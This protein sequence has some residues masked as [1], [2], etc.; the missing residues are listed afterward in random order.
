MAKR[1]YY[2]VLG[3][4][5]S[6]DAGEI[7]KAYRKLAM[8]YH[9]D[10]NPGSKAAE[11]KFKEAA[12]AYE[13]LS[14]S[15]KR[16]AYD[17]F[18]HEG[19][20][21]AGFEGFSGVEDIFSHFSDLFGDLFGG[22]GGGRSRSRGADLRAEVRLTF[23]EAVGGVTKDVAITRHVACETCSGSGAKPGTQPERCAT[24]G[25]RG[26]VLHQQGFFMIGTTCPHCRGEGVVIREKCKDCRGSGVTEKA[27]SLSVNIPAGVDE[28][29]RLRLAGKGEPGPRGGMPGNLYVDIHVTEDPRFK[30]DGAD[31]QSTV[32]VSFTTAALGGVAEIG[33]LDEGVTGTAQIDIPAGTQPGTVHV[34][35]GA[36]IARLDGYGRGDHYVEITVDVPRQLNERQRELLREL[37]A[38]GGEAV[39][40]AGAREER[41]TFFGRKK[42]K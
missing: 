33:T 36:G 3:V 23:A 31:V 26:Q 29:Q 21:R 34:R 41:R 38:A 42:K 8:E 12:E 27:E 13:V 5:R 2:E 9:P 6:A 25:G 11:E 18:G 15:E 1:D 7:K 40:E 4:G 10:R 22:S 16:S 24:C 28:G 17:R 20:R 39:A 35:R 19:L 37:A 14:D 30:R 32:K